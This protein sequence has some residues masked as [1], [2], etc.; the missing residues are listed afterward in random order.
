MYNESTPK[1]GSLLLSEPF[2]LDPNFERSVILLCE[3]NPDGTIGLILN[4]RSQLV[5][6]DVMDMDAPDFPLYIGGPVQSNAVFFLHRAFDKL[7]EGTPISNDIYWGGDFDKAILMMNE[8]IISSDEIKFF[9][10]YSGWTEGQLKA[11]IDQNSW[12]V[13]NKYSTELTFITDGEDLWKQALIS[14]GPKYAHVANFPK[15]PNLN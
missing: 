1:Q 13:H 3:H 12:A 6:S 2:M 14:L 15:S 5:L 11:E 8:G 7:Q 9:L 4:Q 10:G